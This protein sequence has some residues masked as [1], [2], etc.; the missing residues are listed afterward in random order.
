MT[1]SILAGQSDVVD[2]LRLS[3]ERA[4]GCLADTEPLLEFFSKRCLE[5]APK[6][7]GRQGGL[8]HPTLV[9]STL[10][11]TLGATVTNAHT[12]LKG[13]SRLDETRTV[14][15]SVVL[16]VTFVWRTGPISFGIP[17]Q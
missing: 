3:S 13:G 4:N 6:R 16:Q 1:R 5:C 9:Y 2:V 8:G 15:V 14:L 11:S 10:V 12:R 17:L 7:P